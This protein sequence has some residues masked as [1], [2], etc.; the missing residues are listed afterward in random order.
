VTAFFYVRVIVLMYFSAPPTTSTT[1]AL[2]SPFMGAAIAVGAAATVVLG[3][4]PSPLLDLA[5]STVALP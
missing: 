3:V 1:V 2:P 4:L 5:A